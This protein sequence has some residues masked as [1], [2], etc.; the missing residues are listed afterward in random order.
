MNRYIWQIPIAEPTENH[1]RPMIEHVEKILTAKR[2]NSATDTNVL[3]CE[4][5]RLVYA[6]YGLTYEDIIII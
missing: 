3:E 5:N 2:K 1:R 4:I 6:I